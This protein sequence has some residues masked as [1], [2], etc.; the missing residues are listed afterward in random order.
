[1]GKGP[2]YFLRK[3]AFPEKSEER[4]RV[5]L[6]QLSRNKSNEHRGSGNSACHC[7]I[8]GHLSLHCDP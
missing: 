5:G 3:G 2:G 4:A 1:M 7:H 8:R 6:G